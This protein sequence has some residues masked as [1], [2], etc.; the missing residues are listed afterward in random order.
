[1]ARPAKSPW[2]RV[3]DKLDV[4]HKDLL[5]NLENHPDDLRCPDLKFIPEPKRKEII[6][7]PWIWTGKMATVVSRATRQIKSRRFSKVRLAATVNSRS[8][9]RTTIPMT[10]VSPNLEPHI[11]NIRKGS[12]TIQVHKF[13]FLHLCGNIPENYQLRF[14][15]NHIANT[16]DLNPTRWTRFKPQSLEN[17]LSEENQEF[18]EEED[19]VVPE[20]EGLTTLE[21]GTQQLSEADF[22]DLLECMEMEC[23]NYGNFRS[24]EDFTNRLDELLDDVPEN[25]LQRLWEVSGHQKRLQPLLINEGT[26]FVV[27]KSWAEGREL[28]PPKE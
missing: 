12:G 8:Y 6:N 27:P 3:L 13:V 1:M 17:I 14:K 22:E 9:P 5:K 10:E 4:P 25:E 26:E 19:T 11:F 18:L 20:A 24:F 28:L 2:L 21:D 7:S 15:K 23:E 16:Y